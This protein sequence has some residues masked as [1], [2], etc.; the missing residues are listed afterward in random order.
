MFAYFIYTDNLHVYD[1]DLVMKLR[2]YK[3]KYNTF[4]TWLNFNLRFITEMSFI[5]FFPLY[6]SVT[7]LYIL[8][9]GG[10]F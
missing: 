10:A 6:K 2:W 8:T 1:N 4:C 3:R 9:I 5:K 7:F